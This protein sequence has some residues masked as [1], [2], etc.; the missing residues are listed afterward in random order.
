MVG[1][2]LHVRCNMRRCKKVREVGDTNDVHPILQL[3]RLIFLK[4]QLVQTRFSEAQLSV[5]QQTIGALALVHQQ[6]ALG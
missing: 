1:E 6:A 2:K 4:A 3:E 5:A